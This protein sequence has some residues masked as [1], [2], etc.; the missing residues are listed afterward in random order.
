MPKKD[1]APALAVCDGC[2]RQGLVDAPNSYG[3]NLVVERAGDLMLCPDCAARRADDP[4]VTVQGRALTV[5][6]LLM[7]AE[8]DDALKA[9]LPGDSLQEQINDKQALN[10]VRKLAEELTK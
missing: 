9:A 3:G 1:D 6:E 8:D 4:V 5:S 7:Q 10:A 2:G